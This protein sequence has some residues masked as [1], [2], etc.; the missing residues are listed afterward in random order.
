MLFT[1]M[2]MHTWISTFIFAL[3]TFH[4]LFGIC[5]LFSSSAMAYMAILHGS[6]LRLDYYHGCPLEEQFIALFLLLHAS[7]LHAELIKHPL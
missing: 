7:L 3:H 1:L 4:Y 2:R 5:S 6:S